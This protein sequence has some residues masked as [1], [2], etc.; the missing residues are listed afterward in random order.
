MTLK[1]GMLGVY[2]W[3]KNLKDQTIEDIQVLQMG[4]GAGLG[5][6]AAGEFTHRTDSPNIKIPLWL[7]T[8]DTAYLW[9]LNLAFNSSLA[10]V[11]EN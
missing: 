10:T 6:T 11:G 8:I 5:Q 7:I 2:S 1:Q 9:E 4:K 3:P